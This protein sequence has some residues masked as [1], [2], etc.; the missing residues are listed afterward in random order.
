MGSMEIK[1]YF[2]C[3]WHSD[4]SSRHSSPQCRS[5]YDYTSLSQYGIMFAAQR[6]GRLRKDFTTQR[7]LSQVAHSNHPYTSDRTCNNPDQRDTEAPPPYSKSPP[8]YTITGP[9]EL[10]PLHHIPP[11]RFAGQYHNSYIYFSY[12]YTTADSICEIRSPWSE[13]RS[14][15]FQAIGIIEHNT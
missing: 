11:G 14:S 8:P 9:N 2:K 10:V 4:L 1:Q 5:T 3:W 7:Q 12:D 15:F 13:E 6:S